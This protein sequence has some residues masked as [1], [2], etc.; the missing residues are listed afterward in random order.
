MCS[1][2]LLINHLII[3]TNAVRLDRIS[4]FIV[5]SYAESKYVSFNIDKGEITLLLVC[6]LKVISKSFL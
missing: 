3:T 6:H 2:V 5:C 4:E 1:G